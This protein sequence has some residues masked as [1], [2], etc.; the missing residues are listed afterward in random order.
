MKVAS[1]GKLGGRIEDAVDDEGDDEVAL[2]AG[3][4]GEDGIELE[5]AQATKDS[6]D[7]AVRNGAGDGKG[8]RRRKS[9]GRGLGGGAVE[10]L[11]EGVD[12]LRG[13][14]GEV[15]DGAVLDCAIEAKR[16]A[17]EDGG[18]GVAVGDGGHIHDDII[19]QK[20]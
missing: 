17:E 18:R 6:G 11:A 19:R 5:V 12:L 7:M 9:A 4:R 10:D 15:G 13:S 1:S 8:S 14:M 2:A 3:V 16:V 20:N